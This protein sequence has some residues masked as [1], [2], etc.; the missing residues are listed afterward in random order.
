[1]RRIASEIVWFVG[2]IMAESG[3]RLLVWSH[4][5]QGSGKGPWIQ[6]RPKD[7]GDA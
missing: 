7:L 1:M 2:L 6:D 4:D 5:I 3:E